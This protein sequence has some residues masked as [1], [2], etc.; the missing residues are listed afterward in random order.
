VKSDYDIGHWN[1]RLIYPIQIRLQKSQSLNQWRWLFLREEA[2]LLIII[3]LLG[4]KPKLGEDIIKTYEP[5]R[6]D[7][8]KWK[9]TTISNQKFEI[10]DRYEIIDTSKALLSQSAKAPMVSSWQQKTRKLPIRKRIWSPSRKLTRPLNTK[11][12]PKGPYVSC[13]S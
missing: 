7:K 4:M 5:Y 3:L 8:A 6:N 11:Y 13:A 12:S 10:Y 1:A 2:N 9:T